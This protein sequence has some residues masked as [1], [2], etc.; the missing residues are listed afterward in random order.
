MNPAKVHPVDD[1]TEAAD[2]AAQELPP[3]EVNAFQE[4][5]QSQTPPAEISEAP[6]PSVDFVGGGTGATV[7]AAQQLPPTDVTAFQQPNQSEIRPAETSQMSTTPMQA[8][9]TDPSAANASQPISGD[10]KMPVSETGNKKK[11]KGGC[12]KKIM[13]LIFFLAVVAGAL[14]G[15]TSAGIIPDFLGIMGK[16]EAPSPSPQTSQT[17]EDPI[18]QEIFVEVEK[19]VGG[20]DAKIVADE[21]DKELS[22]PE[23]N[24]DGQNTR[25][26]QLALVRRHRGRRA[27]RGAARGIRRLRTR[28][29]PITAEKAKA[30]HAAV[31]RGVM[32]GLSKESSDSSDADFEKN[33]EEAAEE[34]VV[35]DA[36][37]ASDE[38][39]LEAAAPAV[40]AAVVAV[41]KQEDTASPRKARALQKLSLGSVKAARQLRP[42]TGVRKMAAAS[43]KGAAENLEED[44]ATSSADALTAVVTGAVSGADKDNVEQQAEEVT[45]EAVR[46]CFGM[47]VAD[48]QSKT[49]MQTAIAA[50]TK[51]GVQGVA[52]VPDVQSINVD[53]GIRRV[54]GTSI[55]ESAEAAKTPS[56]SPLVKEEGFSSADVSDTVDSIS[57][58]AIIAATKIPSVMPVATGE[59]VQ[60][61]VAAV[62]ETCGPDLH[63]PIAMDPV[64]FQFMLL[65]SSKRLYAAAQ[66]G[67]VVK[68]GFYDANIRNQAIHREAEEGAVL[69]MAPSGTFA[70]IGNPVSKSF[71]RINLMQRS[72][73][74]ENG[75]PMCYKTSGTCVCKN[76][77]TGEEC[78]EFRFKI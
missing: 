68:E 27:V 71:G 76:G 41:R 69:A 15:L 56:E 59:D 73:E 78:D 12:G 24:E 25:R 37:Y 53:K 7:G 31:A 3:T 65:S 26:R 62:P 75:T 67:T 4:A 1:G 22:S 10:G 54:V 42:A 13:S 77:Y 58:S 17:Y 44:E 52:S 64:G 20:T 43:A 47:P 38:E 63:S 70:V 49:E 45:S 55:K 33:V 18:S 51:G 36:G 50:V 23:E 39:K 57:E 48:I 35:A 74:R 46:A 11:K 2:G 40:R 29:T 72:A 60:T 5:D 30:T 9:N 32:N 8:W 66:E 14:F 28:S 21:C 34:L 6:A 61:F 19:E 16:E